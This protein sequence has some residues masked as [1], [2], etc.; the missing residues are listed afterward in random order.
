MDINGTMLF[1]DEVQFRDISAGGISLKVDRP[2]NIG[3]EYGLRI[4]DK[5][6]TISV[7]GRV[8]W[9]VLCESRK[10]E[11]GDFVPLYSAGM[12]FVSIDSETVS[13]LVLFIKGHTKEAPE[14]DPRALGGMR[15]NV[16]YSI[17][18]GGRAIL[19][20]PEDY[21][22]K[23]ISLGG[24]LIGSGFEIG[25]DSGLSLELFLPNGSFISFT[26]RVASC[27]PTNEG[28]PAHYDIGIE[29]LDMSEQDRERLRAFIDS[30]QEMEA[31]QA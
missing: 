5:A 30:L 15:L 20:Y 24:M 12:K 17:T 21:K 11:K 18:A 13:E 1:A 28:G 19:N 14:E 10:T 4:K 23:K 27:L 3:S 26:G 25:V 16:R 7:K 22:V 6:K 2:L 9:S 29:F 31:D 8:V